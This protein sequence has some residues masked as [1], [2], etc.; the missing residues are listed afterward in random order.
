[1]LL[2]HQP[3]FTAVALRYVTG[4]VAT[5]A[6]LDTLAIDL[7]DYHLFHATRAELLH[8]LDRTMLA[9]P[10]SA[11][12]GLPPTRPSSGSCTAGSTK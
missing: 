5:L 10:T 4:P 9:P 3:P 11:H 12:C 6:E 7:D 1:M 8:A 2:H